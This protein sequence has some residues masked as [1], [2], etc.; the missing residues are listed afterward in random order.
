M[1]KKSNSPTGIRMKAT[2]PHSVLFSPL[3]LIPGFQS[4]AWSFSRFSSCDIYLHI[5][6]I[7]VM[8]MPL[9]LTFSDNIHPIIMPTA[10]LFSSPCDNFISF[11][12]W[13][14]YYYVSVVHFALI[15]PLST[16]MCFS[17]LNNCFVFLTCTVF[18]TLI[19]NYFP[20]LFLSVIYEYEQPL[21]W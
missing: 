3:C 1:F 6:S 17:R 16:A 14:E 18:Y 12:Q 15:S 19:L 9:V 5:L 4:W 2:S 8:L 10:P 7:A 13:S 20:V 21:L 11:S